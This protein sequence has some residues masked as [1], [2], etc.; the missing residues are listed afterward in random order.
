MSRSRMNL[1]LVLLADLHYFGHNFL[2]I[3]SG[4]SRLDQGFNLF[5]HVLNDAYELLALLVRELQF[6]PEVRPGHQGKRAFLLKLHLAQPLELIFL[7]R[8]LQD[9]NARIPVDLHPARF[10][11]LR[12]NQLVE[13]REL[14]IGNRPK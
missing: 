10:A 14:G 6:F 13:C 2:G 1:A 7:Q 12:L 4:L 3:A 5:L 9:P 8:L 11:R